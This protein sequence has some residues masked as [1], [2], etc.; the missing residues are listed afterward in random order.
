MS[1]LARERSQRRPPIGP[2]RV[3]FHV[4][5]YVLLAA[6]VA[7][8]YLAGQRAVGAVSPNGLFYLAQVGL[9][10]AGV[11]VVAAA[12]A[13][14]T[15]TGNAFCGWACHFGAAQ[16]FTRWLFRRLGLRTLDLEIPLR[17]RA[18]LL[19]K[20][21]VMN[22]AALWWSLRALPTLVVDLGAPEPCYAVG[23]AVTVALDVLVLA[24]LT[25]WTLGHRGFCR[26][27]C[28]VIL[29]PRLGN[30]VAARRMRLDG[31][32]VG[33]GACDRACPMNN[34]V[35]AS[36]ATSGA[37][38]ALDC[39]RCGRCRDACPVGAITYAAGPRARA[40]VKARRDPAWTLSAGGG[41]AGFVAFEVVE[42]AHAAGLITARLGQHL[43]S[44]ELFYVALGLCLGALAARRRRRTA[45][46][47]ET[48]NKEKAHVPDPSLRGPAL[49]ERVR[50]CPALSPPGR[51]SR[52]AE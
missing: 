27:L 33:C 42:Y 6:H 8:W 30:S 22:T 15:I 1:H 9:L 35:R 44:W 34:P 50:A 2:K 7:G 24:G 23:T 4:A 10:N 40:P 49:P 3:A 14:V 17:L 25:T 45:S 47:P 38:D 5:L 41:L 20:M 26:A 46:L 16:D 31:D 32:C 52:G 51:R 21:L 18:L 37:V 43:P 13:A 48:F 36:L 39:V 11:V 28:P 12:M 29:L 19:F